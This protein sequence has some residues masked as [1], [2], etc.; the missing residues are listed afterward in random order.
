VRLALGK[1]V[2]AADLAGYDEVILATGVAPRNPRIPGQ[3]EGTARGQVLSYVDVLLHRRDV[4][5]R[6]AVVGAGGIGFDVS[7]YLV[8]DGP[9]PRSTRWRG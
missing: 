1:R 8:H 6:V 2:G 9:R 4:G 5:K 7:E 3:D